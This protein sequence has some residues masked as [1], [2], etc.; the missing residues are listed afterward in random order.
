MISLFS[1]IL[2]LTFGASA[3]A[4]DASYTN[5]CC[6]QSGADEAQCRMGGCQF[7]AAPLA[8]FYSV[9]NC[10]QCVADSFRNSTRT[11]A[12]RTTC[13]FCSVSGDHCVQVNST[14]DAVGCL[15]TDDALSLASF[16]VVDVASDSPSDRPFCC[17]YH[18][19]NASAITKFTPYQVQTDAGKCPF[20]DS[21]FALVAFVE[22]RFD[23]PCPPRPPCE[24]DCHGHGLCA[25]SQCAC[26]Q[27]FFGPTCQSLCDASNCKLGNCSN[28]THWHD[29]LDFDA[30]PF[31]DDT[32]L[33]TF[34]GVVPSPACHC[35]NKYVTGP[36]CDRCV[37]SH[38]GPDCVTFCIG[39]P[40]N[41]SYMT[42]NCTNGVCECADG[43]GYNSLSNE[44]VC[45]C[46][47]GRCTKNNTC[48]CAGHWNGTGCN[49]C[50]CENGGQCSKSGVCLCVG[51]HGGELCESCKP[52]FFDIDANCSV[53]CLDHTSFNVTYNGSDTVY[54]PSM[55]QHQGLCNATTGNCT[56]A[57]HSSGA[58]CESCD[59][60]YFG[61]AC[62]TFCD[63]NATCSGLGSCNNG[64]GLCD[65]FKSG[66]GGNCTACKD[67]YY[68]KGECTTMCDS[69]TTCNYHGTCSD[70]GL[71]QCYN[72]VIYA[73]PDCSV[74]LWVIIVPCA[75]TVVLF[76]AFFG[77]IW[78]RKKKQVDEFGEPLLGGGGW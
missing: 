21:G 15:Q 23:F 17:Y 53:F 37:P 10:S 67:N 60:G 70:Q 64:T 73:A 33:P 3:A 45:M 57:P 46:S 44:C 77:F 7:G 39:A 40:C 76:G 55:C 9:S 68:P 35:M 49:E 54:P 22:H 38:V 32:P 16:Q 11:P 41:G 47:N 78:W 18:P 48:E 30:Q 75:V 5:Y 20:A 66:F 31:D 19:A 74:K 50:M 28:P 8:M 34:D 71:C 4:D 13:A 42:G 12:L 24:S 61:E 14:S 69:A 52:P 27:N 25:V 65:C 26:D 63:A 72:D 62:G 1:V 51:N 29:A 43:Y 56:C 2:V 6:Q 36:L 59:D 58:W